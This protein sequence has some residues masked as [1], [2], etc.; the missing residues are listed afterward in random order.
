MDNV[1]TAYT[2][3]ADAGN[4]AQLSLSHVTGTTAQ[5]KVSIRRK[6]RYILPDALAL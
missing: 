1:H 4:D 3:S 6:V 5:K 2:E